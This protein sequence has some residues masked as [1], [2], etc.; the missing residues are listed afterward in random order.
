MADGSIGALNAATTCAC[1]GIVVGV[2]TL[3][4]LGLKFSSIVIAYAGGSLLLTAIYTALIVWIIGLA[5]P[6][7]ASY[8]ICA[9]IAAPALTKLGVPDFAAH[10]FIFYYAVLSEVSP[11]TALS[12]FAAAAI[13]GGDPYRTTLQS[14]KYTLPA[15]LVPFVFVLD[16]QG[17]G[18]LLK[19]PKDGSWIDI[20]LITGKT[21]LGLLALAAAA[22]NW[23]LR[24]NTAI[25]RAL[26]VLSGLLLVF[27]SL[28]EAF[29]EAIIGRDISY[30]FVPG[31]IIGLGVVLWQA[32]K[33]APKQPA[34][35]T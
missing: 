18:L 5:V 20:L 7:T 8:I 12:P 30:T 34:I 17:I 25:E 35:T 31:L 28:I 16:P 27:P 21:T 32:W 29:V 22:Q 9:V 33:P 14:W 10:M 26:L 4:G 23:A 15:F 11:P 19:V 6:V 3:T 24:R 1:A 13:T 2:V